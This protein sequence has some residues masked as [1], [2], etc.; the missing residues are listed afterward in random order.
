MATLAPGGRISLEQVQAE[1]EHLKKRWQMDAART[2]TQEYVVRI[3]G[4]EQM[5][6]I[7]TFD[8]ATLNQVLQTCAHSKSLAE[9]GRVL[10]NVSRKQKRTANDT[11]RLRKYLAKFGLSWEAVK[12]LT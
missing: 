1:I 5:Q 2:S 10:F 3:L 7:D 8:Q 12:K 9:A 6:Q 4:P 11:D